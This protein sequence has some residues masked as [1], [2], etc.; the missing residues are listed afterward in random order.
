MSPYLGYPFYALLVG[1]FPHDIFYV[2]LVASC[3][4]MASSLCIYLML[5]T[6]WNRQ[7]AGMASLIFI[8][9][10]S[11]SPSGQALMTEIIAVLPLLAALYLFQ[12]NNLNG[13]RYA[14]IGLLLSLAVFARMN[15]AICV[16][17]FTL[18]VT[19]VV[20]QKDGSLG[21]KVMKLGAYI[22]GGILPVS[23]I[24][25]LY[26]VTGHFDR[27]L[28]SLEIAWRYSQEQLSVLDVTL[29]IIFQDFTN[30]YFLMDRGIF[31]MQ[32]YD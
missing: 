24:L 18:Y 11:I 6:T 16:V 30:L 4:I 15:L 21:S 28:A 29:K 17:F 27:L 19:F 20:F 7:V 26:M 3:L 2:R 10:M 25:L 1:I 8:Y 13:W 23:I 22:G 12:S 14:S 31:C 32:I 5:K 9:F